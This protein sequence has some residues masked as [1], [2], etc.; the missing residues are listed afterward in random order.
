MYS[1]Q[2][3]R[4]EMCW[5]AR[6][7]EVAH[8]HEPPGTVP[9]PHTYGH[10]NKSVAAVDGAR[11]LNASQHAPPRRACEA[12]LVGPARPTPRETKRPSDIDDQEGLRFQVPVVLFYRR[13]VAGGNGDDPVRLIRRALGEALVPYH[14]LAGRLREVEGR[15]LV[16]D[17]SGEGVLF[18][19]ADADVRLAE[20]EAAGLRPPFPCMDQLLCEDF[21]V[22]GSG[23]GGS[24]FTS[25]PGVLNT[26]QPVAAH[27]ACMQV[28][29]LL[30]GGFVLAVLIVPLLVG[31]RR[32][33]PRPLIADSLLEAC[34]PPEPTF[35]HHE[36]D[37]VPLP[38]PP[39][40]QGEMVTR[41][42]TFTA[43]DV[44]ALKEKRRL[45]PHLR[46][47]ATTF[48]VLA[49]S[50]WRAHTAAPE[51]LPDESSA[52]RCVTDPHAVV[53]P[54][55]MLQRTP[56]HCPGLGDE[57]GARAVRPPTLLRLILR[58]SWARPPEL[59]GQRLD[60]ARPQEHFDWRFLAGEA[61][62]VDEFTTMST[63]TK[64][65]TNSNSASYHR[66][67]VS[68]A[69]WRRRGIPANGQQEQG[70]ASVGV[71][72]CHG[73]ST[74]HPSLAEM[75]GGGLATWWRHGSRRCLGGSEIPDSLPCGAWEGQGA[76][77]SVDLRD[78]AGARR[79][80]AGGGKEEEDYP[81]QPAFP[82]EETRLGFPANVRGMHELGLPVGYYGNALVLPMAV[83]AAGALRGGSLGH[84]VELELVR[85][86]KKTATASAEYV[87][88]TADLLAVRGRPPPAMGN[89]LCLSDNRRVGFH[90]V[91][92]GPMFGVSFL[93]DVRNDGD[94]GEDA[95]AVPVM[96]PQRAMDRFANYR[97]RRTCDLARQSVDAALLP[98]LGGGDRY[99]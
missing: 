95:I 70:V 72:W 16:V 8:W 35:P 11:A 49:A 62:A 45:P 1:R 38:R 77:P 29:R 7:H 74:E 28:T 55:R 79:I 42:F 26:Q 69:G 75:V 13:R 83:A 47:T 4:V 61:T 51:I 99:K 5:S 80:L 90:G 53:C 14:R 76:S 17:C 91:D 57:E 18:V 21:D 46:D 94:G 2:R 63:S 32:A 93:V 10:T 41:T 84:A 67:F 52:R 65:R 20:L 56:N 19:E 54:Q 66:E 97:R 89:L 92:F 60:E 50:V 31:R 30:C 73:D 43:A 36:Y 88:S 98:V 71:P 81:S 85:E 12:E 58:R 87:R 22:Q 48:D 59:N 9:L 23:G 37:P 64:R 15:K 44:A 27:P 6:D 68:L 82:D 24:P 34:S 86:A 78:M 3:L 25:S 40:P 96:L 39:P 33:C